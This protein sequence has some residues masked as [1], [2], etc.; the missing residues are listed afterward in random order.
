MPGPSRADKRRFEENGAECLLNLMK[1]YSTDPPVQTEICRLIM[2]LAV[3]GNWASA[4]GDDARSDDRPWQLGTELGYEKQEASCFW[5]SRCRTIRAT[6]MCR[7]GP[8]APYGSWPSI[9]RATDWSVGHRIAIN[10]L[11]IV[12]LAEQNREEIIEVGGIECILSAML[13]H[14]ERSGVQEQGCAALL[15]L[16]LG[17]GAPSCS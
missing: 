13:H 4:R 5:S 17:E 9:V 14:P 7:S 8:L 11:S 10:D 16:S 15:N 12:R 2:E 3:N 6:G 1:V